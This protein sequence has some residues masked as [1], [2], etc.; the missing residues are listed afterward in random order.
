MAS[1]YISL[2]WG[3]V[4]AKTNV[5]IRGLGFGD[6]GILHQL[7]IQGGKG[8]SLEMVFSHMVMV[9]LVMPNKYSGQ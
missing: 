5:A 3:L 4:T 7:S 6:F 8:G 1:P 2:G 9:E